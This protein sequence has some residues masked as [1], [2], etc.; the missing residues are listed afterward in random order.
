MLDHDKKSHAEILR[1]LGRTDPR[2]KAWLQSASYED[3]SSWLYSATNPPHQ[4]VAP[5]DFVEAARLRA[6][7]P[8]FP[9]NGTRDRVCSTCKNKSVSGWHPLNCHMTSK[10][11]IQRHNN[12]T[13]VLSDFIRSNVPRA[14]IYKER[15]IPNPLR[16]QRSCVP[17]LTVETSNST[18]HVDV[19]VTCPCNNK[20]YNK[21]VN[22]S[23]KLVE[24]K[25]TQKYMN[26]YGE[27]V[28]STVVPFVVEA[29]GRFGA[30]AENFAKNILNRSG[31]TA[32][33]KS[34]K[35]KV[36]LLKSRVSATLVT[37]NGYVLRS[38]RTACGVAMNSK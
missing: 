23:S 16:G 20:S 29:T 22:T 11:N 32:D 5:R 8:I 3:I 26:S 9:D 37:G 38:G 31:T 30:A 14:K 4:K 2:G 1:E 33:I 13:D 34:S 15:A 35:T 6:L 7:V 27:Q 24:Y 18:F 28:T 19:A 10:S 17:D 12:V 21:V 36:K 25:K